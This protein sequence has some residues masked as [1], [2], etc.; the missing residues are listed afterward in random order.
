MTNKYTVCDVKA[1]AMSIASGITDDLAKLAYAWMT[2]NIKEDVVGSYIVTKDIFSNELFI[3]ATKTEDVKE[4]LPVIDWLTFNQNNDGSWGHSTKIRENLIETIY[5]ALALTRFNSS[6]SSE[7][8]DDA[9]QW[10]QDYEPED[11][12]GDVEKNALA[13]WAIKDRIKPF[14][15]TNPQIIIIDK[16]EVQVNVVNP[17]DFNIKD[18]TFEFTDDL[19]QYVSVEPI[20]EI[21][22]KSYKRIVLKLKSNKEETHYGF[23]IIKNKNFRLAKI[24]IITQ[25][26]P[27]INIALPSEAIIYGDKTKVKAT[28]NYK[29]N[30]TFVC[31]LKWD[32]TLIDKSFSINTERTFDVIIETKEVKRQS[33][34]V[35][36]EIICIKDQNT[37]RNPVSIYID[38][39]TTKPFDVKPKS[40][41]IIETKKDISFA[42]ENLIDK[43]ITADIEFDKD[44]GLLEFDKRRITVNPGESENVTIINLV[45]D[46][47]NFTQDLNIVVSSLGQEEKIP[48]RVAIIEIPKAKTNFT[49][50]YIILILVFIFTATWGVLK[51]NQLK[52]DKKFYDKLRNIINKIRKQQWYTVILA[53]FIESYLEEKF[54][55]QVFDKTKQTTEKITIDADMIVAV[56]F[57]KTIGKDEKTIRD[58]LRAQG[59]SDAYINE[60]IKQV[61]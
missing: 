46:D 15:K 61:V 26:L 50:L 28:V 56:K 58:K 20:A 30:G 54:P 40:L 7:A 2:N 45:P 59:F 19:D 32:T 23:M 25:K 41:I 3:L 1:T 47:L 8:I 60:C 38:Q 36:G 51:I 16:D 5:G 31:N 29:T 35:T 6:A 27:E 12:W 21:F 57:L 18:I 44:A 14:L 33:R 37:I 53:P 55:L 24:P 39:Y 4:A 17:T 52:T 22:K 9:K 42:I 34:N 43:A 13:F 11:G 49:N 10:T 48:L